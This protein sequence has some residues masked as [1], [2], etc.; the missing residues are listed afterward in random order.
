VAGQDKDFAELQWTARVEVPRVHPSSS[1]SRRRQGARL[2]VL[3]ARY[4]VEEKNGR[5]T[6]AAT[7]TPPALGRAELEPVGGSGKLK[8]VWPPGEPRFSAGADYQRRGLDQSER[9]AATRQSIVEH[10]LARPKLAKAFEGRAAE[11]EELARF[12]TSSDEQRLLVVGERYSGKSALMAE[13]LVSAEMPS[14]LRLGYFVPTNQRQDARSE[15]MV[16][17]L[18]RQAHL[19]ATGEELHLD[20]SNPGKLRELLDSCLSQ[21]REDERNVVLI[22]DGIDEDVSSREGMATMMSVLDGIS[23]P[24]LKVIVSAWSD[25]PPEETNSWRRVEIQR[26]QQVAE[27]LK[28]METELERLFDQAAARGVL[29][30]LTFGLGTFQAEEL[31]QLTGG[32]SARVIRKILRESEERV[33]SAVREPGEAERWG[34]AHP[35]YA[36]VSRHLFEDSVDAWPAGVLTSADAVSAEVETQVRMESWAESFRNSGWPVETPRY[37]LTDY[38]ASLAD[39]EDLAGPCRLIF[40]ARYLRAVAGR[41]GPANPIPSLVAHAMRLAFPRLSRVS[42]KLRWRSPA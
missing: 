20:S 15:A 5:V 41:F 14:V 31:A 36:E 18:V 29:Q 24:G 37:L 42:W 3:A 34:F 4:I 30:H 10:S 23:T 9:T 17:H 26:T 39:R 28:Q 32:C 2:A 6:D 35:K 8:I 38:P 22:V 1:G 19:L 12:S 25:R 13:F 21:T 7:A 40:D 16:T 27:N 11:L 33:F